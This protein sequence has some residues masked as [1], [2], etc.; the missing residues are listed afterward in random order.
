M[1]NSSLAQIRDIRIQKANKLRDMGIDPYPARS[2]KTN[3]IHEILNNY[4]KFENKE[5]SLA[6]RLVSW[7][8]HGHLV[9]GHI[10]DDKANIQ[11]YIK[12]NV[13][14]STSK[15]EQII[16]FDDLGLL[17]MGDIVQAKGIVTKTQR[18][19]ISILPSEIKLLTKSLRPLPEKW[20]GLVDQEERYRKRY[21]DFISD[22]EKLN[23]FRR[24]AKFWE[25]NRE[26][27][28]NNGF[29]EVETPVLEYVTGGADAR[30]FVTYHNDLD[31]NFYLRISTELY[32]KRLI[33]AGFEKI[34]TLAPNFRNE[35]ISDEHLQEY[36]QLEWYWA[37]AD[38]HDSMNLVKEMFRYVAKEVY[39]KTKFETRGHTFDLADEWEEIDYPKII[40]ERFDVDIFTASE[41]KMLKILT[42][43][44]VKL[45]EG[46]I[47]RNRL[48]DNL[49]KVIRKTLSG[50]AFLIN[51]PKFMSPLAKSKPEN[52]ELTERFHIIIG[53]SELGN[54]Y[55]ELNDPIDQFERFKAQQDARNSGDV[56]AQMMDI[57]Y[58]EMLEHGMAPT[59]GYAHSERLFWFLEDVTAREGTLF[60]QLKH[61]IDKSNIDLYGEKY[62]VDTLN[63]NDTVHKIEDSS[64][65]I[66]AS[67]KNTS[68]SKQ[69]F[70][71]KIVIVVNRELENWKIGNTIGHISAYLGN[72]INSFATG[73]NFVTK[74]EKDH[75]RNTQY[76]IIVLEAKPGQMANFIQ[77]VR[78][79]GMLYHGFI[80]E[81]I[82]TS[83]DEEI[84]NILKDKKDE[85]IEYLGIGVFGSNEEVDAITKKFSLYK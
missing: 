59:S 39:G 16:G 75:P 54:G 65:K 78:E 82:L 80:K 79:S 6:G 8:E 64:R 20:T 18:G 9:F 15:T 43:K 40:Q 28:K 44:G 47:N 37:F 77:K 32:Q 31:Q 38:Y 14:K 30:P 41:D 61:K 49:W 7:R 50:P 5:V 13:L 62:I 48:I 52:P 85:D 68:D 3:S 51:E 21:L 36:Y 22:P 19:E 24:K 63:P 35:G 26:F 23:R 17:D 67:D 74:D 34:F 1:A 60:P 2:N 45:S 70:S 76:P 66:P 27:M 12:D 58:V 55:S 53:G 84:T 73:E 4:E 46:D 83:N 10:Q 69:D 72:K 71:K 33:G 25:A 81:M 56:E 29:I 57:D 11:L 42:E